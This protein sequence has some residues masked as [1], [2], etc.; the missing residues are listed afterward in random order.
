MVQQ[1]AEMNTP[2]PWTGF[3]EEGVLR[4]EDIPT[5]NDASR[6]EGVSI[7]AD[8]LSSDNSVAENLSPEKFDSE[9]APL[10][11]VAFPSQLESEEEN[12]PLFNALLILVALYVVCG[13]APLFIAL[14]VSLRVFFWT[15]MAGWV[16]ILAWLLIGVRPP[17]MVWFKERAR[18]R[19]EEAGEQL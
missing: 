1:G 12:H 2:V 18:V 14:F 7:G 16:I 17:F 5:E 4:Q 19:K 15:E 13:I 10:E 8:M 11:D 9:K 6:G 3:P